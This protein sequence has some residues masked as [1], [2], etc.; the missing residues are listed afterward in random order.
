MVYELEGRVND[1]IATLRK[2]IRHN[3]DD[4]AIWKRLQELEQNHP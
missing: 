1:A 4:Q 3:P 2:A